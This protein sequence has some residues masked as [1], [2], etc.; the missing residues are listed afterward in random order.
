M[1]YI[2]FN[3]FNLIDNIM[4]SVRQAAEIAGVAEQVIRYHIRTRNLIAK[5]IGM[6]YKIERKDLDK[7][8]VKQGYKDAA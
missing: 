5:K 8:M 6:L 2:A 4:Y 3:K 7:W 1:V